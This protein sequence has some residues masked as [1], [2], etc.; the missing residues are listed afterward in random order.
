MCHLY[1]STA[2]YVPR[3]FKYFKQRKYDII[4]GLKGYQ[5]VLMF[6][7]NAWMSPLLIPFEDITVVLLQETSNT[8]T[9]AGE[10]VSIF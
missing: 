3:S 5:T 1:Q 2:L 6:H 4:V 9:I 8:F 10:F 7:Y